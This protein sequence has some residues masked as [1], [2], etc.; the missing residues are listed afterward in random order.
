MG[1]ASSRSSPSKNHQTFEN[2]AEI[3]RFGTPPCEAGPDLLSGRPQ[4]IPSCLLARRR[5]PLR[6][7]SVDTH[8]DA[9]VHMSKI[10]FMNMNI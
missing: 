10:K 7:A 8:I 9:K 6:R 3:F 4:H 1:C 2:K 5:H